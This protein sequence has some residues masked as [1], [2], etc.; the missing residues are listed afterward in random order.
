L[1]ITPTW[2]AIMADVSG[3][4]FWRHLR[5]EPSQ[6]ILHYGNGQ[7]IRKGPGVAY[8]FLPLSASVAQ[9]P[10]EDCETTFMLN[11]RSSDL[12]DLAVQCTIRYRFAQPEKAAARINFTISLRN[13]R[14]LEE[15]LEKLA[16]FWSQRAQQP[17][18]AYLTA[19]PVVE[20]MRS[21]AEVIRSSIEK[22]LQSDAEVGAMGLTL[23]SVQVVRIAPSPELEK[24]MQ[25]PTREVIQQKA[26]EAVF[27]RR[28]QAVEKERAIKQ[29]ELG[30]QIEL[31]KREEDLIHQRG[32]NQLRTAEQE[33]Q[34]ERAKAQAAAERL[35][36]TAQAYAGEVQTRAAG[37]AQARRLV[38]QA[39]V[40]AEQHR[41]AIYKDLPSEVL[42][43]LALREAAAKVQTIQHLNITPDLIG[44][45]LRKLLTKHADK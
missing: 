36:I 5:A 33:A 2:E 8:W 21:G 29:N 13:G 39:E 45:G 19:V 26:D 17:A 14:W 10:V 20:A 40:E 27:A 1:A 25:T 6:F 43:S 28:A 37:D 3:F 32:A 22:A 16:S 35:G 42:L 44:E 31:A 12:Q 7:L 11:E 9:V 41:M 38:A 23:V 24:A 4:L 15:P 34:A 18:R 30:T